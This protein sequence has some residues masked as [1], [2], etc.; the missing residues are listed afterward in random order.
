MDLRVTGA[1]QLEALGRDLRR[2][3][4]GLRKDLMRQIGR[5]VRDSQ[6]RPEVARSALASLPRRGGL[7]D[8]VAAARVISR[9]RL[10]G[11]N[12][13]VKVQAR[14]KGADL[15][16]INRGRVRHPVFG[17]AP[18]VTQAVRPGYFDRAMD[19]DV[20]DGVRAAVVDAIDDTARRLERG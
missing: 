12:V 7:A 18:L 2:W 14:A 8:R 6:V 10:A 19:S 3:A 20:V 16:A 15:G 5:A 4:S 11:Q 1:D 17:R 13:G 9:V